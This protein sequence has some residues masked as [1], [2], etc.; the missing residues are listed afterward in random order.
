M[1]M[2]SKEELSSGKMDTVKRSRTPSV[3]LMANGDVQTH[4]EAQVFDQDLNLFVTLQPLEETPAVLSMG[5]LCEDHG[6]SFEWVSGQKPRLTNDWK[7]II[8]K[9]DNFVLLVVPGLSTYHE[10][11][12]SSASLSQDSL[13]KEAER[14]TREPVPPTSSSPSSSVS[15][16]SDELA[17][18][19]L[20]PF[21]EI[22]KT[23]IKRGVT[24]KYA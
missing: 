10:R 16:R 18:R 11:S 8:C 17:S 4:E 20:V 1:H 5:K 7:T 14:A 24:E 9:P 2:M 12:S 21:P 19:T 6:Y 13:R 3:V 22:Q 15:Q 23:K